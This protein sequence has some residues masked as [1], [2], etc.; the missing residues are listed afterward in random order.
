MRVA[1]SGHFWP[2]P[3]VGSGQYLHQLVG[4]LSAYP[5]LRLVLL[6]QAHAERGPSPPQHVGLLAL[7]TPFDAVARAAGPAGQFARN[8][9]KL[10][11]EQVAVPQAADLLGADLL[12]VPYFAPPLRAQ[13]PVVATLHDL[14]PLLLNEYRGSA[15]VRAYMRLVR[16]SARSA[17]HLIADSQATRHDILTHLLVESGRVSTVYLAH[18][19]RYRPA[20][21]LCV[22]ETLA[23][24]GLR[25]PFVYY[26]GGFDARKNLG[27]LVAAFATLHRQR[28]DVQLVLAGKLRP[29]AGRL[30]PDLPGQIAELGLQ[31]AVRLPGFVSDADNRALYTAC[32]AFAFPSRYEGFGLPPLEALAC[33]APVLCSAVSSMPE[34]VGSAAVL[35]P[36]DD[37]GAWA[38]AL[39]RVIGE[40][41]GSASARAA[42]IARAQS[43]SAERMARETFAIYSAVAGARQAA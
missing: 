12:H 36:P 5:H 43:F 42:R 28:P 9:A 1:I 39:L 34:V 16:R 6:T 3:H 37:V 30:F 14:I 35:L 40:E 11:F 13:L 4:S 23:R 15:L 27:T 17:A 7:A 22:A 18:D 31:G 8:L 24:L 33:G 21:P 10:Y 20:D 2:Q 25:Q 26:V 29:A 41:G 32:A 19:A 38:E